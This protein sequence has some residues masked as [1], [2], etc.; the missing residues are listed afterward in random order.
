MFRKVAQLT[1]KNWSIHRPFRQ[2]V[3][4]PLMN[5]KL[6]FERYDH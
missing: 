2:Y 1:K 4:V 3:D 6:N 5:F